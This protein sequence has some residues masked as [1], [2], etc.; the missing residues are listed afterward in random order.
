MARAAR[1]GGLAVL[2]A[3][4]ASRPPPPPAVASR[5]A[6]SAAPPYAR[7]FEAGARWTFAVT[8][9]LGDSATP[10]PPTPAGTLTCTV[11]DV[12]VATD[13][14]IAHVTCAADGP[15]AIGARSAPVGYWVAT[16][17]GL[18]RFDDRADAASLPA[19]L[20]PDQLLLAAIPAERT[21]EFRTEAGDTGLVG[22]R[23]H[24]GDEW[25]V[26]YTELADEPMDWYLCLTAA[27]GITRGHWRVNGTPLFFMSYAAR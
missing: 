18:W 4:C 17:A 25:C 14:R 13:R 7:L 26:S 6:T 27:R 1:L 16:D 20:A 15:H 8:Q 19:T 24:P 12:R 10:P 9:E 11:A 22:V 23:R 3:A 2:V 21:G 5:P